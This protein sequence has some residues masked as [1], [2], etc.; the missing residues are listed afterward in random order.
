[1]MS[2]EGTPLIIRQDL[3]TIPSTNFSSYTELDFSFN[4]ILVIKENDLETATNVMV[5]DVLIR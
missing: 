4:H 5:T 3:T 2:V 1:M